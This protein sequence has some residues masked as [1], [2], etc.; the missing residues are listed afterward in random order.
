[1]ARLGTRGS[2]CLEQQVGETFHTGLAVL[3]DGIEAAM[4]RVARLACTP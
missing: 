3:L 4:T 1:M 2:R